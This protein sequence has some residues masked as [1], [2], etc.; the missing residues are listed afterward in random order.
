MAAFRDGGLSNDLYVRR[1]A[2]HLDLDR[3][4]VLEISVILAVLLVTVV[5][6]AYCN[7]W[8]DV[9]NYWKNINNVVVE[10]KMPYSETVFEYPPLTLI[11]FLIPRIFSWNLDSFRVAFAT[12]AIIT[13]FLGLLC[14]YKIADHFG[15]SRN[16]VFHILLATAAGMNTFIIARYDVFPATMI[17]FAVLLYLRGKHDWAFVVIAA[18]TM[19]KLYPGLVAVCFLLPYLARRDWKAMARG[20]GICAAVALLCE[21]PFIIDNFATAFDYLTY[22]SDRGIQAESV[23]G[24]IIE[25]YNY[26][27]PGSCHLVINYGS[28]NLA[29]PLPDAIAPYMNL[30]MAGSMVLFLALMVFA[31]LRIPAGD[32][33]ASDR[34]IVMSS[35]ILIL[36]FIVFNKVYS[37]QYGIWVLMLLPACFVASSKG[38]LDRPVLNGAMVLTAFSFAAAIYYMYFGIYEID[39]PLPVVELLK[40]LV[41]IA[42]LVLLVRILASDIGILSG[43]HKKEAE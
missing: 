11:V 19:V 2:L 18:A 4:T 12:F 13:F 29:G 17:L 28:H 43:R 35:A 39:S 25:V 10:H 21:L 15:V 31:A 30:V 1:A 40:N 23:I 27:V 9:D 22:H 20:L 5:L 6:T 14:A 24:T 16:G 8:S 3:R 36:V 42:V 34:F 33:G 38:G 7:R 37:A 26:V 32:V 41:T